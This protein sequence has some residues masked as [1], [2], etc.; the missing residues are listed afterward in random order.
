MFEERMRDATIVSRRYDSGLLSWP[1]FVDKLA[2][3][4]FFWVPNCK[5]TG[6]SFVPIDTEQEGCRRCAEEGR[7]VWVM[8]MPGDED[9]EDEE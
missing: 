4:K 8:S 5:Q 6:G 2:E 3:L 1:A 7:R 9:E